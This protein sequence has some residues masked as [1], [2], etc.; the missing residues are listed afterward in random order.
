[1]SKLSIRDL[2]LKNR[3]VFIR[4]DFNVP[5]DEHGR[6]TDDTR[7]VE[8]LPT[9]DYALQHR[10]HVILASHLG[11]PKGKP[12]PK[13][14]LRPV[15]E[16]LRIL[17]DKTK[18]RDC[19]VGFSP[20]CIGWEA[21]EMV[22]KLEPGQVLLLENLRFHPEEEA[23]DENFAK[24]LAKLAELYVNDAFGAAHRAHAST[25]GITKFVSKSA[26]GL[27]VEKELQYLGKVLAN[28]ERPFIT[29]LGGAKVS[30]KIE[31]IRNLM[32]KVDALLIGGAMAY[33]FMRAQGREV[34]KSLVEDD[35]LELARQL[36]AEAKSKG[37]TFLLPVDEVIADKIDPAAQVSTIDAA[38][39]IPAGKMGLDIGPKTRDLYA[40]QIAKAKTVL[41]NGPM[42]VFEVAPFAHGTVAIAQAIAKNRAATSIVGGG[43]SAA[44][45]HQAGVADKITHIST[46]GGA[47]LE[48]LEGKKLPG[49]ETLTNK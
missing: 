22:E 24:S 25:V 32:P 23:N 1:M 19:N 41:W 14:S 33:T 2:D 6:V 16:H 20:D 49:V 13:M 15:A 43:D 21:E 10:A 3:R 4:V 36:L 5:L 26:A 38:Q 27:L 12:N 28:P 47:S 48:F 42:G 44:A 40:A 45:V 18:S 37:L 17:L 39:P 30:D 8:T 7:I 46:G 31:V 11:R 35:K 29:I 34:G 9:I